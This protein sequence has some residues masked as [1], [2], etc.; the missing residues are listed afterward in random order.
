VLNINNEIWTPVPNFEKLYEISTNGRVRNNRNKIMKTYTNN[1]GY[2]CIKF[3]VNKVRTSHLIH[4]LVA[5]TY[6]NNPNNLPEVN[7]ID[8]DKHNNQKLNL[9]WVTSS[10]N[11]QHSIAS[12]TYNAIYETKNSLGKKHLPN[13]YSK[14]H[15]VSFDKAR[16]KWSAMIRVNGK[17][18]F[19]KR[20]N[21]EIE[22]AEHINW[23][24][25]ELQLTDRPK[26]IIDYMCNDYS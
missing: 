8:E 9:E 6:I 22:A 4:R 12:G 17:N 2:E 1:S 10:A 16:N 25:D 13:T 23:I 3:T 14:Y 26:N 20:F 18:M 21:T 11:K 15:N 19:Q 7:H 5:I 24:I